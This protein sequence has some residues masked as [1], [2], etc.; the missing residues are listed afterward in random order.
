MPYDEQCKRAVYLDAKCS[1]IDAIIAREQAVIEKLKEY[2]Q[3]LIS[4]AVRHGIHGEKLQSCRYFWIDSIPRSW[5]VGQLKYFAT[6]RSGITMGKNI[7]IIPNLLIFLICEWQM[8][9]V[10]TLTCQILQLFPYCQKKWRS[11]V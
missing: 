11:T 4:E 8:Y 2:K 1:K 3:I 10:N 9:K 6:I 5:K 7:P